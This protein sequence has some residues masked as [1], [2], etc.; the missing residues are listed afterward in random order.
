MRV[1][2]F[3]GF[4]T[5]MFWG[6]RLPSAVS[7]CFQGFFN[8]PNH[9]LRKKVGKVWLEEVRKRLKEGEPSGSPYGMRFI[10]CEMRDSHVC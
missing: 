1:K 5:T 3:W 9:A 8:K 4:A 6:G 10:V 7:N 2:F